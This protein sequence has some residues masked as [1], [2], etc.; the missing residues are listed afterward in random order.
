[1]LSEVTVLEQSNAIETSALN[2]VAQDAV[3][4]AEDIVPE[5]EDVNEEARVSEDSTRNTYFAS[6]MT[7]S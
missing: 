6:L 7:T 1:V 3:E 5:N 4:E 2:P